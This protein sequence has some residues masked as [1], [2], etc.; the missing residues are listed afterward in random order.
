MEVYY[1]GFNGF[2]QVFDCMGWLSKK[3]DVCKD[4]E[5]KEYWVLQ[6]FAEPASPAEQWHTDPDHIEQG[7]HV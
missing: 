7:R 4:W 5:N 3:R 1:A 2:K 6:S